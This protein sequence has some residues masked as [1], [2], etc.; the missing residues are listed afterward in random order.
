MIWFRHCWPVG[1]VSGQCVYGSVSERHQLERGVL[2]FLAVRVVMTNFGDEVQ[3]VSSF[4]KVGFLL[5]LKSVGFR[6]T[7][8]V[9]VPK[10]SV[11]GLLE[12]KHAKQACPLEWTVSLIDGDV[13]GIVG[14]V[15]YANGM[16]ELRSAA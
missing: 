8:V 11:R 13:S 15:G 1:H 2:D 16:L 3:L 6:C 10:V 7:L 9:D 12:S 14:V 5:L 4:V